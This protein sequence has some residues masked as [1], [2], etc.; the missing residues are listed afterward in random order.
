MYF[1]KIV[2]KIF[3]Y[4]FYDIAKILVNTRKEYNFIIIYPRILNILLRHV[5]IFEKKKKKFLF[6]YV[7]NYSDILT[8][9]EIFQKNIII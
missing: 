6:Q 9:Y 4:S 2:L 3:V 7:R 8:V 1:I 5:L